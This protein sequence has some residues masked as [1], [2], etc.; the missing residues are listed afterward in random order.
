[1][2]KI[3]EKPP[4]ETLF[5]WIGGE[6]HV[7]ALIERFYDLMELEPKYAALR[8]SGSMELHTQAMAPFEVISRASV[9]QIN[10][11]ALLVNGR[12]TSALHS[13]VMEE[14]AAVLPRARRVEIE[15][16]GHGAPSENPV[17]FNRSMHEFLLHPE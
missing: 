14:L 5:E 13:C 11:T 9:A 17:S 6:A 15:N 8:N 1:M 10:I 2:I 4:F 7:K 16:A 12:E 3:Q